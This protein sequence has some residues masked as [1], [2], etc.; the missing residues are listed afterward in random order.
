M[1][2]VSLLKFLFNLQNYCVH[3]KGRKSDIPDENLP[4]STNKM[5]KN[6]M[7]SAAILCYD[8]TKTFF[9]NNIA[10]KV[11]IENFSDI[12]AR[13]YSLLQKKLSNVMI[14]YLLKLERHLIGPT[15]YKI[16]FKQNGNVFS[17]VSKTRSNLHLV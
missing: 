17:S 13:S 4:S 3:G 14:G 12:C 8:V 6:A 5:F 16:F 15:W 11:N 9:I 2:K 7:I 10:I 1:K